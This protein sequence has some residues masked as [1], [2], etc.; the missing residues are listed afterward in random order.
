M[1]D[2]QI[3]IAIAVEVGEGGRSRPVAVARQAPRF[4]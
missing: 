2:V 4:R 1:A 3:E